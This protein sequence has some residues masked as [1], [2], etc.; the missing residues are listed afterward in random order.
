MLRFVREMSESLSEAFRGKSNSELS[1]VESLLIAE[2]EMV[3][4]YC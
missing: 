1:W 3:P 4:Q 2:I